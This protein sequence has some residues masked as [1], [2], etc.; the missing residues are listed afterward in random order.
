MSISPTLI[1][2]VQ[3]DECKD[4]LHKVMDHPSLSRHNACT[5]FICA[6]AKLLAC[7]ALLQKTAEL[8][9]P[10]SVLEDGCGTDDHHTFSLSPVELAV[11]SVKLLRDLAEHKNVREGVYGPGSGTRDVWSMLLCLL[12]ALHT[13]GH[14]QYLKGDMK[15][16]WCYAKEGAMLAKMLYLRGW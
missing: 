14:L 4:T 9:P 11:D 1:F 6:K 7:E 10:R 15:E 16:A 12:K 3:V 2:D 8:K 5:L 13:L